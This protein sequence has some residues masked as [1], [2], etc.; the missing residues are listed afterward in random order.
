[1]S[2]IKQLRLAQYLILSAAAL[3][4]ASIRTQQPAAFRAEYTVEVKDTA[5]HLFH[6][7]A[8]FSNLRQSQLDL[9]LPVWTPGWYTIEN[10]ARN[11]LRFTVKDGSG[12][13]LAAPRSHA[14]T[15]SIDTRGKDRVIAEF[16]YLANVLALNQAKITGQYAFFT[17]TQLFLEPIGHRAAPATVHF[18]VPRGWRIATALRDTPDSATYTAANY[19]VLVDAP[20][21]LGEFDLYRFDVDGKPHFLVQKSVAPIPADSVAAGT[22]RFRSMILAERAIFGSLPYEKYVVFSLPGMAESKAAG[23]LEHLNSYVVTSGPLTALTYPNAHEF[24]HLWNVKRIRPAEMWPYDY[25]R[26]NETPSLWVSEGITSYYDGLIQYRMGFIEET[27][28]LAGVGRTMGAIE[29]NDARRY[30]SPSDA[31]ISTWLGYDTP[32]AFGISYYAQGAVLGALLDL[33][34]RHDTRGQRGL[35]DVMRGLYTQFY[36]K[37]KGFTPSDM[38]QTVSAVAGRDY[39]R[40]FSQY[41]TGVYVP[42]YET[43]FAYAGFRV[44]PTDQVFGY[45]GMEFSPTPQGLDVTSVAPGSPAELAGLRKGDILVS[46]DGKPLS[47][48]MMGPMLAGKGGQRMTF[49]VLRDGKEQRVDVTLGT[50]RSV[51]YRIQADSL[52]TPDQLVVRKS[53]LARSAPGPARP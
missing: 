18:V 37:G 27:R 16:D 2:T 38:V 33:S 30:L 11:V 31:S 51:S 39:A 43:I 47:A 26:A 29:G 42:P 6:V 13:R 19:D 36:L 20:T 40:F 25:S 4:P 53:W 34:I 3:A 9:A 49:S 45:L 7:T 28:F 5:A 8:V 22:A 35:D 21:W 23:G 17:G 32:V 48:A 10:Y 14:S 24:F 50:R 52:A 41:V 15:W 12:A 46:A 1:V 44:T